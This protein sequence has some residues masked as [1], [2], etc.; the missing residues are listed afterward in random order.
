MKEADHIK[1]VSRKRLRHIGSSEYDPLA[2][3]L[4]RIAEGERDQIAEIVRREITRE[5][6]KT[7]AG[8]K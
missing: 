1:N 2:E 6:R 5:P 7:R 3:A 8:A 4:N